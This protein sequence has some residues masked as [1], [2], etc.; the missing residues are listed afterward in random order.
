[1]GKKIKRLTITVD[2]NDADYIT[3]VT[4]ITESQ[5]L[6]VKE[7]CGKIKQFKPYIGTKPDYWK[8]LHH[9]N[10]PEGECCRKDLGEKSPKDIYNIS[11]EEY[12]TFREL[13]PYDEY[14]FHTIESVKVSDIPSDEEILL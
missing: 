6:I 9:N 1:M 10:F 13:C 4:D 12:E 2:T 3:E 5:Y 11:G 14:G 8:S 7:V